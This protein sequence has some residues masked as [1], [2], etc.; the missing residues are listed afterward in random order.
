[1][2]DKNPSKEQH[3][4]DILTLNVLQVDLEENISSFEIIKSENL[5]DEDSDRIFRCFKFNRGKSKYK[6]VI[7]PECTIRYADR[8]PSQLIV[9]VANIMT[10]RLNDMINVGNS[11]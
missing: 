2:I 6:I 4:A 10:N 8:S 5:Y 9:E 3:I 1:M 7:T 11:N